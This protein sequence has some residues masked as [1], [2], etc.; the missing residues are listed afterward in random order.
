[1]QLTFCGWGERIMEEWH[2]LSELGPQNYTY[3]EAPSMEELWMS[4]NSRVGLTMGQSR[5]WNMF[6]RDRVRVL[7]CDFCEIG[8]KNP[9][10][11]KKV[12]NQ[13]PCFK[14]MVMFQKSIDHFGFQFRF[15]SSND[16]IISYF[17]FPE[18][19]PP[20]LVRNWGS[21]RVKALMLL[22]GKN[23]RLCNV[24]PCPVNNTKLV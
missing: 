6:L 4:L 17:L 5:C 13:F 21:Q 9:G 23:K 22:Y 16:W 19:V 18:P 8:E 1:M 15:C 11:L 14:I 24:C 2:A 10:T 3:R 12:I 7:C 20:T